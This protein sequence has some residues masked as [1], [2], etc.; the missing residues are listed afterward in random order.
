MA[1]PVVYGPAYSTFTRSVRL[2]LEEKG[3]DYDLEEVNFIEGWP[4]EHL[5]RHPFAKVP[6]FEHNGLSLYESCAIERYVDEAFDGP[7][8]QPTDAGARARMAQITSIIDSY[9][10]GPAIGQVFIQRAVVPMMG[11]E[12]EEQAISNALPAAEKA[13]TTLNDLAGDGPYLCGSE[14]SLADLHLAPVFDYFAQIP[15]GQAMMDKLPNLA[16]WWDRMKARDSVV[17]TTPQLG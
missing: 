12:S 13:L 4:E 8:L 16:A 10:Y 11:G 5:A 9:T 3:V 1:K 6:A 2:A 7:S 17:K 14:M 15:E